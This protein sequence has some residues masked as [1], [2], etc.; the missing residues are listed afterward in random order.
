MRLLAS[1]SELTRIL[2]FIW[3]ASPDTLRLIAFAQSIATAN[4]GTIT[5]KYLIS[6][7]TSPEQQEELMLQL[8]QNLG[9]EFED[10]QVMLNIEA[11][12]NTHPA[13]VILETARNVDLMILNA[14][15]IH[16]GKGLILND[17]ATPIIQGIN[18][19][20]ILVSVPN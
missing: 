13:T 6:P 2:V 5:L 20:M 11:I 10:R 9:F 17:W 1:P 16:P 18:C 8:R 12:A 4:Q 19:S 15:D 3:D 14:R 7:N